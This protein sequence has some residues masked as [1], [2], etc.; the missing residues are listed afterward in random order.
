[1]KRIIAS[2][3]LLALL[4]SLCACGETEQ[5]TALRLY[6][7]SVAAES[8]LLTGAIEE[9]DYY[10]KNTVSGF[11]NE[12]LPRL[13]LSEIYTYFR[14]GESLRVDVTVVEEEL[15]DIDRTLIQSCIV[16]TLL[17][18]E[19]VERVGVTERSKPFAGT[20]NR[21]LTEDDMIF[22]GAEEQPR[23]VSVELYFPRLG[24]RGL[25][26]EMRQ[27][28]LTE[29]ND[30]CVAVTEALL[31]GPRSSD[32]HTPFPEGTVLLD[33]RLEDG[34]CYV[35]FSAALLGNEETTEHQQDLMLYAIVDTLGNL[36]PVSAVQILVEGEIPACC[37]TTDTSLPLE[38]NFSLLT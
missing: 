18:V 29:G 37:G 11:L 33:A 34:V 23:E 19:G 15:T 35:N 17:Q 13:G 20:G 1:M 9:R 3:I 4:I 10:G 27:L 22:T 6:L 26:F 21:L 28:T 24:G 30:L 38:P 25:G 7:P 16:L 5:K 14:E 36:D 2:I 32:L 31:D 12:L 8:E